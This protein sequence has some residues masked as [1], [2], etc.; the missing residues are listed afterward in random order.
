MYAS[1]QGKP[2]KHLLCLDED[3]VSGLQF[4]KDVWNLKLGSREDNKTKGK[5]FK[6]SEQTFST[7][8]SGCQCY[9]ARAQ[10]VYELTD[11]Q[12]RPIEGIL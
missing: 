5:V 2:L 9:T 8:I 12:D 6:E 4:L 10:P 7:D 3:E 1:K 11:L